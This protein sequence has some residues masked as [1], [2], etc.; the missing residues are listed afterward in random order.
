MI[1]WAGTA[2]AISPSVF[3]AMS[4]NGRRSASMLVRKAVTHGRSR[5]GSKPAGMRRS[6]G[7]KCG[8]ADDRG[9]AFLVVE[10]NGRHPLSGRELIA[11]TRPGAGGQGV[12][13]A[14]EPVHIPAQGPGAG[15]M[16]S[17]QVVLA[18]RSTWLHS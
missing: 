9:H 14:A 16:A 7:S 3:G 5:A 6:R 12:A 17:G 2:S 1:S 4:G 10:D 11:V 13:V 8:E 18:E 15:L